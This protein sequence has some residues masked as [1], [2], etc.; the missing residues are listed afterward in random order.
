MDIALRFNLSIQ[1][2]VE[3]MLVAGMRSI[4]SHKHK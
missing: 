1:Y 3:S 4:L 2:A